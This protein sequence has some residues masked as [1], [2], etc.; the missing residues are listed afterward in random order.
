MFGFHQGRLNVYTNKTTSKPIFSVVGQQ[1][2]MWLKAQA[3]IASTNAKVSY[4]YN[5]GI[6]YVDIYNITTLRPSDVH[7]V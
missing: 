1:G 5:V 2:N 7:N 6:Y 4:F 3:T